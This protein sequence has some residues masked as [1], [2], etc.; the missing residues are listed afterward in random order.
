MFSFFFSSPPPLPFLPPPPPPEPDP[1]LRAWRRFLRR[2]A[3][4]GVTKAGT[5]PAGVFLARLAERQ[6]A[7]AR[8]AAPLVAAFVS[9][10]YAPPSG[11]ADARRE[12]EALVRAL[13][14]W[15]PPRTVA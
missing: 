9:L 11:T 10:R 15:R 1:L 13:R 14:R 8:S 6:P 5:E 4:L 12:R 7:A 3:R 2:C